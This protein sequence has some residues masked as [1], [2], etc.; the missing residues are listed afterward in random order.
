M[1]SLEARISPEIEALLQKAADLQ[2]VSLDEFVV[3]SVQ[4]EAHRVIKRHQLLELTLE[5]SAAFV[6]TLL[7]PPPPKAAL[8]RAAQRYQDFMSN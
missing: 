3:A 4:A 1:A 2:G 7:N 8:I 5:D 6:D